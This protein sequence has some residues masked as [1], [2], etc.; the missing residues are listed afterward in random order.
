MRNLKLIFLFSLLLAIT[1]CSDEDDCAKNMIIQREFII[2]SPSGEI[3]IP[4]IRQFVD[5]SFP[6][7]EIIDTQEELPKLE[8][9]SF[10]VLEF[11]FTANTGN[12]T[13]RLKYR[14]E[15]NNLSNKKVSGIPQISLN[16]DGLI[17]TE[18]NYQT[19]KELDANSSCIISLD[20]EE[21]LDL[22][23]TNSIS[24]KNVSYLL[25]NQ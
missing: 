7:P 25:I 10:N 20:K 2:Q 18:I 15:L 5:C 24:L 17:S 22:G 1:S 12:N 16:I 21:S 6:Q 14:I 9:F 4:E 13:N 23:N 19:C 8:E 3:K 11:T